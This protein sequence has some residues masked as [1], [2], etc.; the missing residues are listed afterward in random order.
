MIKKIIYLC[1]LVVFLN[2]TEP[3]T[4]NGYWYISDYDTAGVPTA[5]QLAS[6]TGKSFS[7]DFFVDL[8]YNFPESRPV[9]ANNPEYLLETTQSDL[10]FIDN[11]NVTINFL[12]EGAGF[13][14]TLA[15]FVY[16]TNN[17]PVTVTDIDQNDIV[18]AIPNVSYR[19]SGGN[20]HSGD[21]ITLVNPRNLYDSNT[22]N[23]QIFGDGLSLGW[24]IAPNNFN[25]SSFNDGKK[26]YSIASLNP[27]FDTTYPDLHQTIAV[28]GVLLYYDK[29][30]IHPEP[31]FLLGF[32][33]LNRNTGDDDFNDAM[34][35]LEVSP[36]SSILRT[37][38]L[39]AKGAIDTDK[40]GVVDDSDD[41]PNDP[42][43]VKDVFFPS[44]DNYNTLLF[45]DMWPRKG[46][47]DFNDVVIDYKFKVTLDKN[48]IVRD[49][50]ANFTLR[51]TGASYSNGFAFV[52]PIS[53]D[54]IASVTGQSTKMGLSS[55]IFELNA[56][57]TEINL[58]GSN[59]V[60]PVFDNAHN[61]FN[62][63]NIINTQLEGSLKESIEFN[64][65]IQFNDAVAVHYSELGTAPFNPFI[66]VNKN[67]SYE[68]HL[69][70]NPATSKVNTSLFY[71]EDDYSD[72]SR[73]KTYI[74]S[75]GL[76]WVLEV[77]DSVEYPIEEVE[78]TEAYSYFDDWAISGGSLWKE[79]FKDFTG[80]QNKDKLFRK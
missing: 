77:S 41:Y 20:L 65:L 45:E 68:V 44:A 71:T 6:D 18:V 57:G 64:I 78:I 29:P 23:D 12:H 52:L 19:Y 79:W 37:G 80:Y 27:E 8:N 48:S 38:I 62:S 60:I 53:T 55:I 50:N 72:L 21:S 14:N 61:E 43:R 7:S 11:A 40:D 51:A 36:M 25:K 73:G 33:D 9:P 46:D 15:Y 32:E 30:S 59:S 22:S 13:K 67:R 74:T 63:T 3:T 34:F 76:P 24:I 69:I 10:V 56:N 17:K 26:Y 35:S 70:N 5:M 47:F 39:E 4:K 16:D 49:I 58:G 31:L 1:G 28:H 2:A 66:V 75:S 54:K 42:T